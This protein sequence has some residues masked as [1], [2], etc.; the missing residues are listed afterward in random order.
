MAIEV[1]FLASL[2]GY[3]SRTDAVADKL[4]AARPDV[5]VKVASPAETATLLPKWKLKFG[6][7][8]VID[9]RVEFVGIPR[10][11]TLVDRIDIVLD[12]RIH[13]PPPDATPVAASVPSTAAKANP[14]P[15]PAP[16]S[17]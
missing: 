15:P 17:A 13:P 7:A 4:R 11:R 1:L 10:L 6:P 3:D 8:V 2:Q 16:P 9:G 14:A 5:T 12:R